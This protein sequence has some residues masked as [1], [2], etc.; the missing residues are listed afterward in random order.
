MRTI[1][2][3]LHDDDGISLVE[4]LV[5]M[6]II[7]VTMLAS[8]SSSVASLTGSRTAHNEFDATQRAQAVVEDLMRR[9][10]DAVWVPTQPWDPANPADPI[11]FRSPVYPSV[12]RGTA[13]YSFTTHVRWVDDPC[14]GSAPASPGISDARLDYLRMTVIT[15]WTVPGQPPR[16]HEIITYRNPPTSYKIA[17]RGPGC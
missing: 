6:L 7:G 10:F 1:R 4:M 2:Q 16:S 13:T 5:A 8:L 17:A 15:R 12:T 3:R 9:P 11:R 14:N